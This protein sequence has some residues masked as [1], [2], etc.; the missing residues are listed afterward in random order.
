MAH[1]WVSKQ[2]TLCEWIQANERPASTQFL[3]SGC[4]GVAYYNHGAKKIRGPDGNIIYKKFCG[5][6]YCPNCG[7][8]M[9]W[10]KTE[11]E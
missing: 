8:K 3:C 4:G 9:E 11:N 6:Q 10:R 1:F 7:A 2:E 5:Y